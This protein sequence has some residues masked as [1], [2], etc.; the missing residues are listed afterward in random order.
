M[1]LE[2]N[3]QLYD[4][5]EEL[6][7][8]CA[9]VLIS[10]LYS[11]DWFEPNHFENWFDQA[12]PRIARPLAADDVLLPP[13]LSVE[14]GKILAL[15]K[16]FRAHAEEFREEVPS[17]P[18]FFNKLPETLRG[19]NQDVTFPAGYEG[20]LDHEVELAVV[21]GKRAKSVREAEAYDFIAGFSI[22]NDLT[23][24]SM[25]GADREKRHPWF[26]C[27][28]FDGACPLGPC[29]VLSTHFSANHLEM[30]AHVNGELRQSANTE[31]M[32]TSIS[33]AVSYLSQ[34]VTLNPGDIVLMGTPAGVGPLVPG[35]EV[36]CSID[37][38]G[39]LRTKIVSA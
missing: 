32:V 10:T 39:E 31:D 1:L 21:I 27:K 24:R 20:R 38:I 33:Q 30:T 28:N 15:G 6:W 9:P 8:A 2:Y 19:H 35:D 7:H 26:R 25:Q 23:L 36:V 17:E 16:N 4:L 22:A 3:D 18:I 12:A 37:G 13:L 5:T 34:H 14:V 11:R 29:F